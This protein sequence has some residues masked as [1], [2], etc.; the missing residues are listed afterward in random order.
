VNIEQYISSGIIESYVLGLASPEERLEFEQRCSQYPELLAAREAFELSLEQFSQAQ[1]VPAPAGMKA[2]IWEEISRVDSH[3][4]KEKAGPGIPA[5]VRPIRR[6]WWRYL[7]AASIILLV[8]S[9]LLNIYFYRQ[10][11]GSLARYESLFAN[12]QETARQNRTLQTSLENSQSSIRMMNDSN[13]AVIALAG[14]P[15]SPSSRSTIY[16]DRR[17]K[18]VYLL[19]GSL[20]RPVSGKQYQL[21][22]IVDGKPVDAGTFDLGPDL[23]LVRMKNIPRAEAFAITLEKAGGSNSPTL[24]AMYVMGRI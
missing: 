3:P 6:D 14:R 17:T 12:T 15:L 1:A 20:P 10:Y 21:W 16:W 2:R 22:A 13:M 23:T 4:G 19:A 9:T 5:P 24:E 7:A 8:T 18:D 11:Q